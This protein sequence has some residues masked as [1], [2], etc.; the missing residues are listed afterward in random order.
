MRIYVNNF[1][2]P[3]NLI[4][5]SYY[6][7]LNMN[8]I[9]FQLNCSK[10]HRNMWKIL[11]FCQIN[12]FHEKVAKYVKTYFLHTPTPRYRPFS[13]GQTTDGSEVGR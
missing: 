7:H 2:T 3:K 8:G 9:I 5:F 11:I 12:N 13:G 4:F 6:A 10:K 1:P